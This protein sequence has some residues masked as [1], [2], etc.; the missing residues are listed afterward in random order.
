MAAKLTL[1]RLASF[2]FVNETRKTLSYLK[3]ELPSI[4]LG[5]ACMIWLLDSIVSSMVY[6]CF[7]LQPAK[8]VRLI[9]FSTTTP[10]LVYHELSR[11]FHTTQPDQSEYISQFSIVYFFPVKTLLVMFLFSVFTV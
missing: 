5:I 2:F 10:D 4:A 1:T 6:S 3:R 8:R 9:W 11:D 7:M